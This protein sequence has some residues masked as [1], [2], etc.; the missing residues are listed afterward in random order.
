LR[1]PRKVFHHAVF[2]KDESFFQLL[3]RL[4]QVLAITQGVE[5]VDD[6][7]SVAQEAFAKLGFS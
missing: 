4:L 5:G 6:V 3:F 1:I 2:G 7:H